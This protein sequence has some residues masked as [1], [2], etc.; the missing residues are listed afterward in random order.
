DGNI[1][2]LVE[3]VRRARAVEICDLEGS[4]EATVEFDPVPK[5]SNAKMSLL[6]KRLNLHF[7]EF[8]KLN[9]N[10]NYETLLQAARN[11]D[12]ERLAD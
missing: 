7:E 3:G 9:P 5:V 10:I 11:T 4:F 1:R 8:A 12:T 2:V 6:T